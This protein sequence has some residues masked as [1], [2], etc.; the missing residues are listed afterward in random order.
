MLR[1][2]CP[3]PVSLIHRRSI[4][5]PIYVRGEQAQCVLAAPD[6]CSCHLSSSASVRRVR[7]LF[8]RPA[9]TPCSHSASWSRPRP[10][11][12]RDRT[13]PTGTFSRFATSRYARPCT[14]TSTTT[15]R[16]AGGR[17]SI[18]RSRSARSRPRTAQAADRRSAPP[19]AVGFGQALIHSECWHPLVRAGFRVLIV[20]T[21][22]TV[23]K[24]PTAGAHG[25]HRA[26]PAFRYGV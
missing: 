18:A 10:R 2:V 16:N 9:S 8:V 1:R 20:W 23:R 4:Q 7:V 24:F 6:L 11:D 25:N 15:S 21:Q 17:P 13:V 26:A 12:S 3:D 14:S 22:T 19:G 5:L